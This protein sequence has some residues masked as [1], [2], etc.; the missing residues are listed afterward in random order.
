MNEDSKC[1]RPAALRGQSSCSKTTMKRASILIAVFLVLSLSL[2]LTYQ[3]A[4]SG[5]TLDTAKEAMLRGDYVEA[6]R[7]YDTLASAP[8]PTQTP[9]RIGLLRSL[10]ITGQYER[11]ETLASDYL[12]QPLHRPEWHLLRGHAQLARGK[13]DEA[14]TSFAQA[15]QAASPV[16]SEAQIQHALLLELMGKVRESRNALAEEYERLTAEGSQL[17]LAAVALQH[18][19]RFKEA[20][21]LFKQATKR[22]DRDYDT[23][24]AWGYLYLEKYNPADAAS[25]FSDL[26]KLNARHPEALLGLALCRGEGAGEEV[27][28]L[29]QRALEV[30]PNLEGAH[31]AKAHFALQAENLTEAE[32]EIAR[33]FKIN[34]HS[35]QAHALNAV[36]NFAKGQDAGMRDSVEATLRIN[37]GY[38]EIFES[39][40][41][42]CV[43][44]RLYRESVEFFRKAIETNPRLWKA[45]AALGVNLLRIGDEKAAKAALDHGFE[46]DPY[47]VWTYNTLKLIDSY[48]HFTESKTAGFNVRLHKKEAVLLANYVPD[49]LEEAYQ[50]LSA[51]YQFS[52]STPIY[53]EMFPDH[54]DFAVRTLG[55]PGLGALGVCF[56]NGVVMDSPSARPRGTFNW[57]STL[58]HEFAHVVTLQATGHRVPR[59]FTE[60]L[61]VMEEHLARPG[62]GDDLNL[63]IV[64]AIQDKKLLPISELNGGFLRPRFPGQVQ[65]SYFQAGQAC[66]FIRQ[67]FGF[68]AILKMLELFKD[69]HSLTA[70]LRQ[71]VNISPDEFDDRFNAFLDKQYGKA[72][73]TVDF[74]VL[75]KRELMQDRGHLESLL[76]DKPDNFFANLK[77]ASYH[78]KEGNQDRAV[79]YLTKAKS[80]FPGYV[81]HDNPYKQLSE[82]YK[83][84][85][86]NT[87]A[88]G[89]LQALTAIHD[90]DF[91]SLKQL[92]VWLKEAGK[93]QEARQALERVMFIYPF[94]A[95]THQLLAG[96]AQDSKDHK[97]AL[98]EYR[99]LLAL[100][101]PDK[102]SAHLNLARV[103]LELGKKLEAKREAL[104]ALEIAPGFEPAQELLLKTIESGS[105]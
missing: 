56:G 50:T 5:V 61:S 45:H 81:E 63:E 39:L 83:A 40:G 51:K 60:G 87:E 6:L 67:E 37:P 48:E 98:R 93:G 101:P 100:D 97:V 24:L 73:R 23:W 30:N 99:A 31:A 84:R 29:L 64:K 103:L 76:A 17:G 95:E 42:F 8:D 91:D 69:R 26:L 55:V 11:A 34:P 82:I 65:L 53:F 38:G 12:R 104:A 44:Q 1:Q 4:D 75:E 79:E 10:L 80:L 52:P 35:L 71:A 43:T 70:T 57:G 77:L 94:D 102:A 2:W 32:Q 41:H 16:R 49:L 7:T 85:G 46:N 19:E 78:R 59:W 27:E 90:S 54:E 66:E 22:N 28:K 13:Y 18:L 74:A 20:D 96:L 88:I 92:A 21:A 9:A 36:L 105:R 68:G 14:L 3:Q 33:C 25:T 86:Q 58:W 89:E 15:S 47:N 62:W 72:V